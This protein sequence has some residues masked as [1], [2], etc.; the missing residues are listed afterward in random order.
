MKEE[1]GKNLSQSS[2]V[3]QNI[4]E[5]RSKEKEQGES[6][7]CSV[8][9]CEA[10]FVTIRQLHNHYNLLHPGQ[11]LIQC[12]PCKKTFKT[13]NHYK[14]HMKEQHA[15]LKKLYCCNICPYKTDRK[16]EIPKHFVRKHGNKMMM[17]RDG[18]ME[19]DKMEQ[20]VCW[21]EIAV[22]EQRQFPKPNTNK[23]TKCG[24]FFCNRPRNLKV[25]MASLH[26]IKE[27][28]LM[29][30]R[31]YCTKIFVTMFDMI[32]HRR[33]CA[34]KCDECGVEIVRDEK[35]KRHIKKCS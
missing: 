18:V 31:F 8:D 6:H 27:D 10:N 5:T 30:S 16:C 1:Q 34:F 20:I 35:V 26:A 3:Q 33:L 2:H 4:F 21:E 7:I 14:R 32:A 19:K 9:K 24:K 29:C 13:S 25:H 17:E 15:D 22:I 11:K 28:P 12:G 23:C